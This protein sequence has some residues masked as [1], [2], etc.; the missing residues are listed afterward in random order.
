MAL[1]YA[2]L[3]DGCP[4]VVGVDGGV[5][6]LQDIGLDWDITSRILEPPVLEGPEQHLLARIRSEQAQLP[7]ERLE[8][9]IRRSF[10]VGADGILRRR[11]PVT[12]H[13]KIVRHMWEARVVQAYDRMR[14]P[15]MCVLAE[16][17]VTDEKVA[18]VVMAKQE[19]A[20]R[21]SQ[22]HPWVRIEW[23]ESVHDIPVLHPGELVYLVR[24]F[25]DSA[26]PPPPG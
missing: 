25:V 9:V 23:L 1:A 20:R 8:P 12:D 16:G 2:I 17:Y 22:R 21:L 11:T 15:A 4:G 18:A 7:W 10:R 26:T 6:D 5:I 3:R 19:C 13:M 24:S 14:C